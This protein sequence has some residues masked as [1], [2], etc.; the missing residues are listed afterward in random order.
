A[1]KYDL[2]KLKSLCVEKMRRSLVRNP[3]QVELTH[4]VVDV[5][6]FIWPKTEARDVMREMFLRYILTDMGWMM[7]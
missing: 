6:R 7:K 4:A 2:E 5:L 3:G 1:D